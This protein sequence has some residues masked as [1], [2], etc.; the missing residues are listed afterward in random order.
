LSRHDQL[1]GRLRRDV[2]TGGR[3]RLENARRI[4]D[5]QGIIIPPVVQR[6]T[7]ERDD[8]VIGT[9]RG[10]PGQRAGTGIVADRDG[11]RAGVA[12]V[13][14]LDEPDVAVGAERNSF[15]VR[16]AGQGE[17]SHRQGDG[18]VN[19]E[20]AGGFLGEPE[21]TGR[22]GGD[23]VRVGP[24]G[25]ILDE[26]VGERPI[27]R[28]DLGDRVRARFREPEI[29]VRRVIG[30]SRRTG[31]VRRRI[32]LADDRGAVI[33]LFGEPDCPISRVKC[34]L[35]GIVE[36]RGCG[37][38]QGLMRGRVDLS[39]LIAVILEKVKIPIATRDD[40]AGIA[41]GG[42]GNVDLAGG[43]GRRDGSDARAVGR[44]EVEN[45]VVPLGD[46]QRR[47]NSIKAGVFFDGTVFGL[48]VPICP[49]LVSVNQRL[50][51]GP[52]VI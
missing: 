15:G 37:E 10:G 33:T 21:F 19:G 29:T 22:V 32:E 6:Q 24:A 18:V 42:V 23:S 31:Y 13:A 51:S 49:A 43:P 2:E 7:R 41:R 26:I 9:E 40:R 28:V 47:P 35:V 4:G 16:P 48:I 45:A 36:V 14:R 12:V 52:G 38:F 46:S 11:D 39:D 25:Q 20:L 3:R 50:P 34:E 8:A 1:R 44:A 5:E 30:D 17:L 27:G